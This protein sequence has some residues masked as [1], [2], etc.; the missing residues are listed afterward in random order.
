VVDV[1]LLI[2]IAVLSESIN[3]GGESL[4]KSKQVPRTHLLR[5]ARLGSVLPSCV[6]LSR[7]RS[8]NDM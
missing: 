6:S 1:E 8:K 4:S 3:F 5:K 2:S 7:P